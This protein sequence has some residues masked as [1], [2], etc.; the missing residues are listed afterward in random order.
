M[1]PNGTHGNVPDHLQGKNMSYV[2][3]ESEKRL[4]TVGHY[5]GGHFEP[6]SD[7]DSPQDAGLRVA[8][9]NGA[10]NVQRYTRRPFNDKNNGTKAW[11]DIQLLQVIHCDELTD[12]NL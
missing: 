4:W 12:P 11:H 8:F 9:L 10:S 2:Y 7:H 5:D 1:A 6:E 3:I